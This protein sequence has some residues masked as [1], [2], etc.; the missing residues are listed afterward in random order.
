M[1]YEKLGLKC[2]IEI[3]QRLSTKHKLFCSCSTVAFT[4][5][6][7]LIIKRRLRAVAGEL[8]EVDPAALYEVA[9]GREF[10]YQCFPSGTCLVETDSEPPH[11]LN[12]EALEIALT[13]AL[14]LKCEINN[15]IHVMRKTVIDGSNTAGFQRTANIGI[16][17]NSILKTKDGD[18]RIKDIELEEEAA[19]IVRKEAD[20]VVYRLDRL[21]IPLVEIGTYPDIQT[22]RQAREVAEKLGMICRST[23]KAMRGIGTIRQDV[24]ISI[25]GGARIEVKGLQEL[26]LL[27]KLIELE[28]K[29][30]LKLLEIKAKLKDNKID[31]KIRNVTNVFDRTVNKIIAPLIY[32]GG[33]VLALKAPFKGLLKQELCPG[34]TLG[35]ELADYAV[36]YDT[37]GLIH[38][39]EDLKKYGLE[40]EFKQL[41]KQ[42]M[43]SSEDVIIIIAGFDEA[44][45]A[46]EAVADRIEQLQK[47]VPEETRVAQPDGTTSYARPLPGEKRMYPETDIPP[48]IIEKTLLTKLKKALPESWE[49]KA[50][51]FSKLLP[52]EMVEQVLR[53]EYLDL[54]EQF[55]KKYGPV[56]VANTFISI[57]KDLRRSGFKTENL[58]ERH[59]SELFASIKKKE[60]AKE[61][62]SKVLEILCREPTLTILQAVERI[63]LKAMSKDQLKKII[64]DIFKA[65][66]E[67][68]KQK[69]ISALMGEVMKE[70]RGKVPGSVVK[71]V[72]EE[73]LHVS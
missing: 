35:R 26:D 19:G 6:P 28:V 10:L 42:L 24:N 22:P 8:G 36:A 40:E 13:I 57:I 33:Q 18:V 70:V 49:K 44:E 25:K 67:L 2:G 61:A 11:P 65:N 45:R 69:R 5:K 47:C 14:L 51:R 16:G 23:G 55:G 30:Q 32:K 9:K 39:D 66:P 31:K 37:K 53:S 27:E 63:G 59:F 73:E 52:K 38:S 20:R 7:N 68:V 56:V 4:E 48:I 64:K 3:H 29:R 34:K 46:I 21:G 15:E 41:Q 62:I 58:T 50:K 12:Q 71:K 60:I 54:F 72:L 17:F 43:T 1:D